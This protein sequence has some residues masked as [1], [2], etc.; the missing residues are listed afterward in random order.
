[1]CVH[2]FNFDHLR[3]YTSKFRPQLRNKISCS[4][5]SFPS[6]HLF[7]SSS[8]PWLPMVMSFFLTHLLLEVA[9]PIIFLPSPFCCHDLQEAKNSI[10]KEDPRPKSST[11]SYIIFFFA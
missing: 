11:W 1:M 10:D 4:F 5:S 7:P 8:Y 6:T 9:S 3:I 2:F